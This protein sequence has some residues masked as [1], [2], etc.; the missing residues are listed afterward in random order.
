MNRAVA[1]GR[2]DRYVGRCENRLMHHERDV[3]RF[4]LVVMNSV[5]MGVEKRSRTS[6]C[7]ADHPGNGLHQKLHRGPRVRFS[8]IRSFE[9]HIFMQI[10]CGPP[11]E[12]IRRRKKYWKGEKKGKK[13]I[14]PV[15]P[16][17][18]L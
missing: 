5:K 13:S 10:F 15:R 17:L 1:I 18:L 11:L 16:D 3:R 7:A 8:C 14:R 2:I 6:A 9:S 12:G 4:L